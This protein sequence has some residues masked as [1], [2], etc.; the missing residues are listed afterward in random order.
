MSDNLV[1][2]FVGTLVF[3]CAGWPLL[4][5]S[6]LLAIGIVTDMLLQPLMH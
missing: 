5:L 1:E 4:C 6:T 2:A 3:I